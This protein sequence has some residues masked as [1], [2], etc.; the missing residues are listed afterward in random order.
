MV[1]REPPRDPRAA[2]VPD[3]REA[4]ETEC[5]HQLELILGHHP[6]RI[7]RVALV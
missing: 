4:L 5:P 2:V 1:E 6:L 3:E 7:R